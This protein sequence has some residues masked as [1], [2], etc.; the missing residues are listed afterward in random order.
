MLSF[1]IRLDSNVNSNLAVKP[2][3]NSNHVIEVYIRVF[4]EIN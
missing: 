3:D 1:M 2:F 4:K